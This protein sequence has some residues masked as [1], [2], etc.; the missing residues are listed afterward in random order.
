[1]MIFVLFKYQIQIAWRAGGTMDAEV[2]GTVGQ[3]PSNWDKLVT[4]PF[5]KSS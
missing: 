1:M 2:E 4:L 5:P 3:S